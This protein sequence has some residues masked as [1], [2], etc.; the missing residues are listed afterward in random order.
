MTELQR[1]LAPERVAEF[2]HDEFVTD[3]VADFAEL[4][5]S[6]DRQ[7][8]VVD[9]GGGV[10]HFA[11]GIQE[12][13]GCQVRVIDMDADSVAQCQARGIPAEQGD[14]LSQPVAGDESCVCLNLIL[15][16]LVGEDEPAT[17]ALQIRALKLW[18]S[19]GAKL[20][21]NEYIYESY[22]S[23]FSGRLIYEITS[24]GLLSAIGSGIAKIVP[25]FRANTF[26]VGVRFRSHDEW[27]ELFAQAGYAVD[28]V[29][30][31][32]DEPIRAPLRLML[33]KAIRRDSYYL[34]TIDGPAARPSSL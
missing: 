25:A 14:A 5:P 12:T 28:R 15:H 19:S 17:R 30:I 24:S 23:R 33:I 34:R 18:Q 2:H 31:G 1:T 3:Q 16:H 10:G 29:R 4:V 20:F 27:R 9:I 7:G 13:L 32:A 8:V 22:I 21:V 26:G 11:Q 6:A